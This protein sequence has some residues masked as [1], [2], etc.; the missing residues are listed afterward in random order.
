M[1]FE[2]N[3]FRLLIYGFTYQLMSEVHDALSGT[4]FAKAQ[5]DTIRLSS[6]AGN[7]EMGVQTIY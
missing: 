4:E 6:S 1:R 5:Y 7:L 2:A 3:A